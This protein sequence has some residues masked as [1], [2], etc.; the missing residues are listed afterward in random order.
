MISLPEAV[1]NYSNDSFDVSR[2]QR[3]I[4]SE[5]ICA[6]SGNESE[7]VCGDAKRQTSEKKWLSC[8]ICSK[9]IITPP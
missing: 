3:E 5:T 9:I 8:G 7:K 6:F 2:R 4:G 1:C